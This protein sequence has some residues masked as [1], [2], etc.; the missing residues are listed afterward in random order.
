MESECLT[1]LSIQGVLES[2]ARPL[3]QQ[4]LLKLRKRQE[5]QDA[6]EPDDS[7][8]EC[9]D[10]NA[11]DM[12]NPWGDA[13]SSSY[14]PEPAPLAYYAPPASAKRAARAARRSASSS[15]TGGRS[16]IDNDDVDDDDDD[17]E[18]TET[19]RDRTRQ[20]SLENRRQRSSRRRADL[21][22][23]FPTLFE[24]SPSISGD[25][26]HHQ[27][28]QQQ[29]RN[30]SRTPPE[31]DIQTS[32]QTHLDVLQIPMSSPSSL[33]KPTIPSRGVVGSS[34]RR[35]QRAQTAFHH[36]QPFPG[37]D[38]SG[39]VGGG[40]CTEEPS[41]TGTKPNGTVKRAV[42]RRTLKSKSIRS[43]K[44]LV[45]FCFHLVES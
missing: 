13:S 27:Q 33:S 24:P 1:R 6:Q 35:L 2:E 34:Q 36:V 18:D 39:G 31:N 22:A 30:I 10:S 12:F 3:A 32:T 14:P 38:T 45:R 42:T 23:R 11:M 43:V 8:S 37:K 26:H 17:E 9:S 19:E 21:L 25:H 40:E 7:M 5:I 41:E 16:G 29:I 20:A 15:S 44:H 4:I 28:Q